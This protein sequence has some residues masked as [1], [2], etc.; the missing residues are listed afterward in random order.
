MGHVYV[1]AEL[2]GGKGVGRFRTLVDTGTTYTMVPR[3]IAEE[4]GI[5]ST[6]K[7]VKVVT[8][9]GEAVLEEGIA[10]IRLMG[11][12]RTNVVLISD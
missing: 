10:V 4:L 8:A 2:I 6:G 1:D 9:K 3:R 7:R 5:T 12:G 11:E